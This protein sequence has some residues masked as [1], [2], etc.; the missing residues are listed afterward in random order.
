MRSADASELGQQDLIEHETQLRT[1]LHLLPE[2]I[3]LRQGRSAL[4]H[5]PGTGLL[6]SRNLRTQQHK[7]SDGLCGYHH[8]S[9]PGTQ[10]PEI[11]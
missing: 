4:V 9:L 11:L 7:A 8:R 2:H 10:L 1:G 6:Q 5:E 3:V